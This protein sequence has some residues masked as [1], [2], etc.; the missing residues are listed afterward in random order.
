MPRKYKHLKTAIGLIHFQRN[1]YDV[2]QSNSSN[3]S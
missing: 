3:I 2:I 1:K